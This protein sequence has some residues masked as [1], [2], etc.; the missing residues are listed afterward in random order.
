MGWGFLLSFHLL[1]V[2]NVRL[3]SILEANSGFILQSAWPLLSLPPPP[4][5]VRRVPLENKAR[6]RV[7]FEI[8]PGPFCLLGTVSDSEGGRKARRGRDV[9]QA[10]L[11]TSDL[12]LG[13]TGS[14]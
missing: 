8:P 4:G 13:R 9:L 1:S 10:C 11:H 12:T 7:G 6:G 14:R 5:Q 3:M 2:A